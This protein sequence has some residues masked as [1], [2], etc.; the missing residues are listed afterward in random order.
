MI[1][2]WKDLIENLPENSQNWCFNPPVVKYSK[3]DL[4][5]DQ[6]QKTY[7]TGGGAHQR[8]RSKNPL[9]AS[10]YD[11]F[12]YRS[13]IKKMLSYLPDDPTIVDLGCGDGRGIEILL[14]LGVERLIAL[15]FNHVDLSLLLQ[16]IEKAQLCV[17]PVCASVTDPPLLSESANAAMMLEVAYTLETPL[18]AYL[19]CN[20]WLKPGG[21]A[22]VSNVAIE[23]YYIHALL[24][25]DWDQVKRIAEEKKYLDNLG[26]QDILV[27]LYDAERMRKDAQDSGFEIIESQVVPGIFGLL[28]HA[29]QKSNQLNE[30]KIQL[31]ETVEK[32]FI[33]LPR[34]YIDLLKK[35]KP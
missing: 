11:L 8:V 35:I 1:G 29:L 30:D 5:S 20:R 13:I 28:L 14:K 3:K 15:D 17:L 7:I 22:I 33:N 18:E 4:Q 32:L 23:S 31:L 6:K 10:Y 24:N 2:I 27:H 25:Q 9:N 34:I 19:N 26:G 12:Y 16:E 21:Y